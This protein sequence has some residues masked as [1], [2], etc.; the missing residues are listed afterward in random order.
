[1]ELFQSLYLF[2]FLFLFFKV[3]ETT[4]FIVF[5][6]I[7]KNSLIKSFFF[8]WEKKVD[9][10]RKVE[11]FL[12]RIKMRETGIQKSSIIIIIGI[13][14]F[15]VSFGNANN[16][17][18]NTLRSKYIP[19]W[20]T[21]N[22]NPSEG[23]KTFYFDVIGPPVTEPGTPGDL[24]KR[25]SPLTKR[26]FDFIVERNKF[27]PIAYTFQTAIT[28]SRCSDLSLSLTS[29][30]GITSILVNGNGGDFGN[31]YRGT[32]FTDSAQYTAATYPFTKN[33]MVSPLKPLTPLGDF[34]GDFLGSWAF[35]MKDS[36]DN[37]I[38]GTLLWIEL[39]IQSSFPFIY[40]FIFFS[41]TLNH[42]LDGCLIGNPCQNGGT[43]VATG[44][45]SYDCNCPA[46]FEGQNCTDGIISLLQEEKKSKT[47]IN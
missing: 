43:C 10:K 25:E 34:N 11:I 5:V 17:Y 46:G 37:S 28:H 26:E 30:G 20:R 41:T 23:E 21:P 12:S 39:T 35:T 38:Y 42:L 31:L 3:K 32:L 14:F 44:P 16:P 22:Y 9:I 19:N 6:S 8:F 40:F 29:P 4:F 18:L 36:V 2:L 24:A 1:L 7:S 33:G 45:T 15:L 47:K 13:L 27:S